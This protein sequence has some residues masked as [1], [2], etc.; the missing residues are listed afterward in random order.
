MIKWISE[1]WRR[2]PL[3]IRQLFKF[4]LVGVTNNIVGL[5][6]NYFFLVVAGVHYLLANTLGFIISVINAAYLNGRFVFT[7]KD[8]KHTKKAFIKSAVSYGGTF[9]FGLFL[10]YA[11]V[12]LWHIPET[13]A[14]IIIL[15][16]TVPINF[17]LNKLWAFR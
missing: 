12:E 3:Q 16:C 17:S 15:F 1:K 11:L 9:L 14:P 4:G 8:D 13:A 5:G 6:V 7:K 10:N 2:I